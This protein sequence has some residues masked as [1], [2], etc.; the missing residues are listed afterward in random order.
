MLALVIA[1]IVFVFAAP[2][3]EWAWTAF[4]ALQV[5]VL[6]AALWTSG[7]GNV[8]RLPAIALALLVIALAFIQYQ[9][10][11]GGR[12]AIGLLN[13]F[14]IVA[15][16]AV[17]ALGVLD[18]RSINAQSVLG[19]ITIYLLLGVLF[20][21][22]FSAVAVLD[23]APFFAQGTDGTLAERIYFSFVTLA[24]LG[25]GDF[26]AGTTAGRMLAVSEAILGQLYLVTVVAV[27]V[28]RLGPG[29]RRA[30]DGQDEV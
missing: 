28:A 18:Q 25:Y 22:A 3:S 16:C 29:S 12:T 9:W 13:V 21:F 17:I 10:L 1:M 8:M 6:L 19:V 7:V 11:E 27:V 14:L 30:A 5:T 4:A 26:T 23:S 15:T 24:T 2:G 20:T